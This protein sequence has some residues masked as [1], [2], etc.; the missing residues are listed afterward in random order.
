MHAKAL[1]QHI[2]K[3]T[4]KIQ[5]KTTEV[6]PKGNSAEHDLDTPVVATVCNSLS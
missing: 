1:P 5:I 6:F 3:K 2:T 4:Q